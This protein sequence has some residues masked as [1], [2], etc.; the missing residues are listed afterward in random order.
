MPSLS[1]AA[2]RTRR[3]G[4]VRRK[5]PKP[6]N[7]YRQS[8][9]MPPR[10]RTRSSKSASASPASDG[11]G[12]RDQLDPVDFD[13]LHALAGRKAHTL[14]AHQDG[15]TRTPQCAR[16]DVDILAAVFRHHEAKPFLLVE[17]FNMAF[18]HWARRR[19]IAGIVASA[20]IA[21]AV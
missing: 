10:S 16:M 4:I 11:C 14:F 2:A 3:C 6:A 1:C 5:P 8:V 17:E 13:A 15:K 7:G 18:T 19:M 12:L 21:E 20:A 9:P